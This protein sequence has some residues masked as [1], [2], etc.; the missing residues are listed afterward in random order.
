VTNEWVAALFAPLEGKI[1]KEYVGQIADHLQTGLFG[2][3][4]RMELEKLTTM[5]K[6][7][8][9]TILHLERKCDLLMAHVRELQDLL[10]IFEATPGGKTEDWDE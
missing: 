5:L 7:R 9:D 8:E 6:E 10:R 2:L 4:P 1:P 3:Y